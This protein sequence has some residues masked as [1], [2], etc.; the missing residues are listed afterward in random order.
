MAGFK[1]TLNIAVLY[2]SI[3]NI[4][5]KEQLTTIIFFLIITKYIKQSL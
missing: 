2:E 4:I 3:C 5:H 1:N